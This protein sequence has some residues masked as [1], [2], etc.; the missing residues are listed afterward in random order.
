MSKDNTPLDSIGVPGTLSIEVIDTQVNNFLL[1][2]ILTVVDAS[3]PN[4]VQSKAVKDLI[5]NL[6]RRKIKHLQELASPEGYNSKSSSEIFVR[7][8]SSLS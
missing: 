4:E 1:G 6:F 5:K 3:I 8:E 2:D 7:A